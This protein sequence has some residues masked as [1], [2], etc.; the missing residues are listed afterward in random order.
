MHHS[1]PGPRPAWLGVPALLLAAGVIAVPAQ[2]KRPPAPV[3]AQISGGTLHV[4]GDG[5]DQAL[6]MRLAGNQGKRI[7]VDVG[8]DGSNDFRF[9]RKEV[10]RILVEAGGGDDAVRIDDSAGAVAADIEAAIE[11]GA[12]DDSLRGGAGEELLLGEDGNDDIAGGGAN[13]VALLGAGDDRYERGPGD[14]SDTIEGQDGRDELRVDG[15]GAAEIYDVAANGPRVRVVQQFSRNPSASTLDIDDVEAI[16]IDAAGGADFTTVHELTGT[17]VAEVATGL[18]ADAQAD[19]VNLEGTGGNDVIVA[20]GSAGEARVLGLQAQVIVT[21][22][23]PARDRLMVK[24]LAGDDVVEAVSLEASAIA[25]TADGAEGDDVL[26]GGA[27]PD[28]LLGGDGDDFLIGGPGQDDLDGGNGAN[29]V[30]Q[31]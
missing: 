27:G 4:V 23:D 20:S 24:A 1:L 14:G 13:D 10:D 18:G 22:A 31:D 2:A 16:D 21:A 9:K 5:S 26:I 11:G 19:T 30:I 28:T 3:T 8:D 7:V 29:V 17:D 6:A 15:S 25:L 12:G